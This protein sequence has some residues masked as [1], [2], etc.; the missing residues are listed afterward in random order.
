MVSGKTYIGS[1]AFLSVALLTLSILLVL[2]IQNRF[3]PVSHGALLFSLALTATGAEYISRKGW[4]N[5][6]IP[7]VLMIVQTLFEY[8]V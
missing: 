4:D 2:F 7:L 1:L 3:D 8:L 6:F 5:F